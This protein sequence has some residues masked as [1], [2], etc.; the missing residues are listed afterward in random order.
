M[1]SSDYKIKKLIKKSLKIIFPLV[2]GGFILFWVYRNFDFKKAEYVL[3]H[4]TN[5]WWM[6]VS[7][8]FGAMSHIVR[9]LRWRQ[10]LEPLGENPKGR[11]CVNAVFV[12]YAANLILPRIGEVSRCGVL[13]KYEN[14][15]FSKSLGT[16]VTER[17]IDSIITLVIAGIT[18]MLQVN[19]FHRFFNRT[20]THLPSIDSLFTSVEFYIIIFSVIG[21]VILMYYLLRTLSF[22]KKVKG[23]VV[24]LWSGIVSLKKVHNLPLFWLYT[25]VIWLCYFLQFYI[26]FF[27]FDFT[28][29]LN[30]LAALV[31]FVCG[32]FAVVVPTPN[33]AGPW[34]FAIIMMMSL[35]GVNVTDAGIFAIIVHSIQTLLIIVLGIYGM[36]SLGFDKKKNEEEIKC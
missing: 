10:T 31:L 33:G 25:L 22:F 19:M 27:C 14:V 6:T 34:H 36:I 8:F 12:S 35:Y 7:L 13:S 30:L 5:W 29:N 21:V 24:N 32:T 20:G 2:F 4:G 17:F 16:V 23:V 3:V 1:N 15:S 11:T 18:F 9:G 26:T 28:M